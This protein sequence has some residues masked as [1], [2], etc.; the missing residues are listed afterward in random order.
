MSKMSNLT[1]YFVNRPDLADRSPFGPVR[2]PPAQDEAAG[3]GLDECWKVIVA[4][5]RVL[6]CIVASALML[7]GAVIFS[8]TPQYAATATLL[9]D[10][11]PPRLMDVSSLLARIQG[12]N[13]DDYVQTQFSLL[14]NEQ[15]AARIIHDLDLEDNPLFMARGGK[16]SL[17][18]A[19]LPPQSLPRKV[20]LGVSDAALGAYF[21]RLRVA[22]EAGTRL[23]KVSFEFPDPELSAKIVNAHVAGY[24]AESRQLQA[25]GGEAARA[26]LEKEAAQLKG[27]VEKS[28]A[29]LNAYRS[30]MGILA[31]G[32]KDQEKNT[33]AEQTMIGLNRAL[34][35]AQT[36]SIKAQAEMEMVRAGAFDSLP[37]VVA[38]PL[39]QN[40]KPEVDRLRARYAELAAT[41][42][43]DYPRLRE[44]KARLA[45]AKSRL[46]Q[47]MAAIAASV[48]RNYG[49]ARDRENNLERKVQAE[50][51]LDLS[52]ND[53][54]LQDAV[55]AREVQ[56][57]R[58]VY[59]DVL[60]RMQEISVNGAAPLSNISVVEDA[61]P[62]PRPAVPRKGRWLA[63]TLLLSSVCG[64]G[65]VFVLDQLDP[66]LRSDG[67]VERYLHLPQLGLVPD[68]SRISGRRNGQPLGFSALFE[69]NGTGGKTKS[70]GHTERGDAAYVI[71]TYKTIRTSLLYSRAGGAPR[72]ILF[73]SAGPG[74][75]KTMTACGTALAFAQTG[76]R[77]LLIDA[78]LRK[79]RCHKVFG[80]DN[81]AGLSE[82]LVGRA[83]LQHAIQRLDRSHGEKCEGLFLLSAGSSA[84]NPG[85]LLNSMRMF[86]VLRELADE[87]SF[88][89]LDS[90][91]VLWVS[92]SVGLSTMADG[93][94]VVA[95]VATAKQKIRA[96]CRRL[97][98]A[99]TTIYGVVVNGVDV[100]RNSFDY[101][102][103]IWPRKSEYA[104]SA[105]GNDPIVLEDTV[106]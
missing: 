80:L 38:N 101:S 22:P 60:K 72:I 30:K 100:R 94:V 67:E 15:L 29:A 90:A 79:P 32:V 62:P 58:E 68:F 36:Q 66:R 106:L 61:V 35:E 10:P 20:R 53:A 31:F 49:A 74:E 11:E 47:E 59:E 78:D 13:E 93:A 50:K 64:L 24:L 8:M 37:E 48:E 87:F 83:E 75:G 25:R 73:T 102:Y 40:L 57:N 45:E 19:L 55:L 51:R 104:A 85:E 52:L 43:D 70:N 77:T 95:G 39:I 71:E 96:V 14:Q 86:D 89:I 21:S 9:I 28:E 65:L 1:P 63:L 7:A 16:F 98:D 88:V 27:K 91:P 97:H 82:V 4:R 34:T 23:V 81:V 84:P 56:T 99:G 18:G 41:Y 44:A 76:G 33:I 17:L 54:S 103:R 69:R 26:F 105:H 3:I 2:V 42:N 92:D 6:A 46:S 12:H 5:W